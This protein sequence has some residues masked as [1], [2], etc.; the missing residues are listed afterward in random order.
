M[1]MLNK[2]NAIKQRVFVKKKKKMLAQKIRSRKKQ[3]YTEYRHFIVFKLNGEH[4]CN[5]YMRSSIIVNQF[6]NR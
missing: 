5:V 2:R 4:V 3:C 6:Y 1:K